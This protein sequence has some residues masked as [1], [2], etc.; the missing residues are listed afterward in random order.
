[1]AADNED[2]VFDR[3]FADGDDV[4]VEGVAVAEM[5][6]AVGAH[7][8]QAHIDET[9]LAVPNR[10]AFVGANA[11]GADVNGFA[12]HA[13]KGASASESDGAGSRGATEELALGTSVETAGDVDPARDRGAL[14]ER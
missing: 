1:H 7:A 12:A 4:S 8:A 3:D 6:I 10:G 14:A 2:V 5:E 13:F 9:L 11:R